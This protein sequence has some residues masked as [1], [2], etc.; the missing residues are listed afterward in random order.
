MTLYMVQLHPDPAAL[1]RFLAGQGLNRGS[2][3]DL[4][5][6]AHAW[7]AATF[8]CLAPTPFRLHLDPRGKRPAKLLAYTRHSREVLLDHALSFAEPMARDVC[9][10]E[11][12]FA[13]AEF[14]GPER[15]RPGRRLGFEVLTCPIARRARVGVERDL[16]LHQADRTAPDA[17]LSRAKVYGD[18]FT[19]QLSGIAR[20]EQ[21]S[22]E[23]F[24]L[25]RQLRR[26]RTGEQESRKS[27]RLIRPAALL[28]GVLEIADGEA[29]HTLLARGVGR[30]RTFGYGMLLLRPI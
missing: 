1:V 23:G 17:G 2:D 21:V 13:V 22:L 16:F 20:I 10:L 12:D 5:Y 28:R 15:W 6:G 3:S 4:G 7:L 8:G 9:T 29:F 30:H 14:P 18:W 11:Q 24:Q 26:G 27:A 25:V 19:A